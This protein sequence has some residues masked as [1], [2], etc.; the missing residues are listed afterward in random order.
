MGG[1]VLPCAS[2]S[3]EAPLGPQLLM[4]LW[5]GTHSGVVGTH[6][7]REERKLLELLHEL[8]VDGRWLQ[9]DCIPSSLGHNQGQANLQKEMMRFAAGEGASLPHPLPLPSAEGLPRPL[10]MLL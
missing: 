5:I 3:P 6:E 1:Q 4:K 8:G 2:L 9:F 7:E 10:P